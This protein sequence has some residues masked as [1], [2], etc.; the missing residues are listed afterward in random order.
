MCLSHAL[1]KV[2]PLLRRVLHLAL[3]PEPPQAGQ[4]SHL[5]P[6]GSTPLCDVLPLFSLK[7]VNVRGTFRVQNRSANVE[8]P[9]FFHST[10]I[11]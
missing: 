8:Q 1:R 5:L 6:I 4:R 2:V 3:C 7:K 11:F 10:K 9:L